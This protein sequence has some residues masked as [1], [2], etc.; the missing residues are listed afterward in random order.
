[1]LRQF[2]ERETLRIAARAL[3]RRDSLDDTGDQLSALTQIVVGRALWIARGAVSPNPLRS[4]APGRFC[5]IAL[6]RSASPEV[7][8]AAAAELIYI[9]DAGPEDSGRNQTFFNVLGQMLT[10]V[11]AG[12]EGERP[13]QRVHHP[14]WFGQEEGAIVRSLASCVRD[15]AL[16]D[17]PTARASLSNARPIAGDL[18]LGRQFL[19]RVALSPPPTAPGFDDVPDREEETVLQRPR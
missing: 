17:N 13:L 15:R 1:V 10:A 6:D 16:T 11:L 2:K 3:L 7:D 9:A 5:V 18:E 14:R 19:E 4:A 12:D 8:Y